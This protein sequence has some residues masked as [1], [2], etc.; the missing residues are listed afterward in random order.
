MEAKGQILDIKR[1]FQDR[2]ALITVQLE[3]DP[4]DVEELKGQELTV[5]MKKYR[6][7]RKSHNRLLRLLELTAFAGPA[8]HSKNAGAFL[9]LEI[10]LVSLF[11][12]FS[13]IN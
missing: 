12:V 13:L 11:R 2:K 8:F 7:N 1:S 6:K 5:I 9:N 4:A 10:R 3:T